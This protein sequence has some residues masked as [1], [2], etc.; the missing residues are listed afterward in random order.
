MTT[1]QKNFVLT[2]R[3]VELSLGIPVPGMSTGFQPSTASNFTQ[4]LEQASDSPA[5]NRKVKSALK[6]AIPILHTL[7]TDHSIKTIFDSSISQAPFHS[8]QQPLFTKY[9]SFG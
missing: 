5:F 7:G 6:E 9:V 3:A 8:K 4:A 2:V 1:V